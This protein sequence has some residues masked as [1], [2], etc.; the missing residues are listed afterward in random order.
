MRSLCALLCALLFMACGEASQPVA[1]AS[2]TGIADALVPEPDGVPDEDTHAP[3]TDTVTETADAD[4]LDADSETPEDTV[5]LDEDTYLP[6]EDTYLPPQDTYVPPQDTYVPPQDTYVPPQDTYVPPQDTYVPPQDTYV[7]PQDTYVPPQDTYVPPQDTY[8]APEPDFNPGWIGGACDDASDCF[9]I[10]GAVC[11]TDGFSGGHCTEP[12]D[13]YC[14]DRFGPNDSVSFCATT[15]DG[16]GTCMARCS[17]ELIPGTG[18]R[19]GYAC[20]D[21]PRHDDP[22]RIVATCLPLVD[23]APALMNDLQAPIELAAAAAGLDDER[24]AVIDLGLDPPMVAQINGLSPIYPASMIKTMLLAEAEHQVETGQLALTDTFVINAFHHT[25][26]GDPPE[27]P[28]PQLV[29]GDVVALELLMDLAI[30]RSDNTAAN[31][32]IDYLGREAVTDYMAALGLPTLQVYRMVYGCEPYDD[33]DWDGVHSNTMTALDTAEL[34][35]LI[36]DGGPGFVGAARRDHMQTILA[37]QLL[38]NGISEALPANA[39]WMGKTGSTSTKTHD[40]G[41]ILWNGGRYAVAVF[42]DLP[43]ATGKPLIRIFADELVNVI[44]DRNP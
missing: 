43:P 8:V 29:I 27:D 7:P 6:P 31:A 13:L 42:A 3:G 11:L 28:R 12:C 22:D 32:L 39:V 33:P 34:Y 15:R 44:E 10:D 18:C 25:C 1:D 16:F 21:T 23:G 4:P 17:A 36:L 19:P 24:I 40:S 38:S 35:A 41:L 30:T 20:V 2:D 26:T 9:D 14:P 5:V 37:A